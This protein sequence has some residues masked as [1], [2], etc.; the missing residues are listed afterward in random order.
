MKNG[1]NVAGVS[2]LMHEIR[3]DNTQ[4]VFAYDAEAQWTGGDTLLAFVNAALIG[5][6]K[7][8]RNFQ[9]RITL[10]DEAS[11]SSVCAKE[12]VFTPEELALTGL[13]SCALL[14]MVKGATTQGR[15]IQS[16]KFSV[17]GKHYLKNDDHPA[18]LTDFDYR[19][20]FDA[21]SPEDNLLFSEI[22][23]KLSHHSPNHRTIVESNPVTVSGTDLVIDELV[24]VTAV[25]DAKE[26]FVEL[27]W[28]YGFQLMVKYPDRVRYTRVDQPKQG[29]GID[30]GANPQ[31]ILMS[32]FAACLTRTFVNLAEEQQIT[33]NG[34]KVRTTGLVDM[35]GM[36][37]IDPDVPSK[38]Q[39]I[40]AIFDVDTPADDVLVNQIILQS[41]EQSPITRLLIEPQS[42]NLHLHRH[43]AQI[44]EFVSKG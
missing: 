5:S 15:N 43:S 25:G 22:L 3:E 40:N 11:V 35:R 42:V 23:K 4:G 13:G 24:S 30:R 7:S 39:E 9:W 6:V 28:E 19:V 2:E 21:E 36:L 37:G 20:D 33:L 8:A 1:V 41:I 29:G 12:M 44:L 17:T 16:L 14:T 10:N 26:L 34:L 32:A 38:L 31:E 18:L 27:D